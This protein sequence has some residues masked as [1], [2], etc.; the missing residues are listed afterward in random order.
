[1]TTA[2]MWKR[3]GCTEARIG[4]RDRTGTQLLKRRSDRG[5]ASAA[6]RLKDSHRGGWILRQ[7]GGGPDGARHEITAT[8][9]TDASQPRQSAFTAESAL[10]RADHG[11][12]R[13]GR[14][15]L[16]A[17]FTVRAQLEQDRSPGVE[18]RNPA[19]G[20]VGDVLVNPS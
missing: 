8:V 5:G 20:A 14:E 11:F 2:P 19:H 13:F 15:V 18:G 3:T 16:V 10:I 7:P 4:Y 1:M 6:F 12:R 17:A 9:G